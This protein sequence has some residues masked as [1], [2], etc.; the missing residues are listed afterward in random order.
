MHKKSSIVPELL[1]VIF[2]LF[3][4]AAL[5]FVGVVVGASAENA[6]HAEF[7]SSLR[8]PVPGCLI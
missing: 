8:P 3:L 4:C 6:E 2:A 5:F 1:A 7:V